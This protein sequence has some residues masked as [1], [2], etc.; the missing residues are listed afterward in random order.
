MVTGE[1]QF[2]AQ[3]LRGKVVGDLVDRAGRAEVPVSVVAGRVVTDGDLP[4]RK[5]LS[6]TDLAGSVEAAMSAPAR[7]LTE[8]GRRLAREQSVTE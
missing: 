6:L 5:A 4:V 7:W 8:A 1:G 3:S 2:D